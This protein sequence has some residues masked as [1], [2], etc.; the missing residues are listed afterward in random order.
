MLKLEN[1]PLLPLAVLAAAVLLWAA[2]C[3]GGGG[4]SP[5]DP[6]SQSLSLVVA[7]VS[8]DGT[9]YNG[10]TYHHVQGHG[11]STRFEARLTLGG[12]PA[13]GEEM[14]VDYGRGMM[15]ERFRLYDDGTHG[16]PTAGDGVYCLED[17]DGEYGFH[18]AGAAHGEYHYD[19]WGEHHDGSQSNHMDV[20]V[21]VD[22]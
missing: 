17:F 1:T 3:D 13:P 18:H 16:D 2:A 21:Q 4:G 22:D 15:R 10:G 7:S 9:V 20:T 11:D 12:M 14:W 5:T 19:F 6:G 8:V